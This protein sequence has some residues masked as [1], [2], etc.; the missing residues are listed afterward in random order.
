MQMSLFRYLIYCVKTVCSSSLEDMCSN[1]MIE[2]LA[3]ME[4]QKYCAKSRM[5]KF[6]IPQVKQIF[7]FFNNGNAADR[8]T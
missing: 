4:I 3:L 5:E 6:E 7:V 1:L 8:C 2:K